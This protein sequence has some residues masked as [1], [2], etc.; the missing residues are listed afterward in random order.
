MLGIPWVIFWDFACALKYIFIFQITV[1]A[2]SKNLIDV[3]NELW[4][5]RKNTAHGKIIVS[6]SGDI[7]IRYNME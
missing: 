3:Y 5:R 1:I 4:H 6:I 7:S 2:A